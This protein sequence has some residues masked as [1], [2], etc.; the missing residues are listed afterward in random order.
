M[1]CFQPEWTASV[2]SFGLRTTVSFKNVWVGAGITFSSGV[3]LGSKLLR[4]PPVPRLYSPWFVLT[5][6]CSQDE[7][8]MPQQKWNL[9]QG[10]FKKI[11]I[12]EKCCSLLLQ[13][14]PVLIKVGD[15][16]AVKIGQGL[17]TIPW[18]RVTVHEILRQ[19]KSNQQFVQN[20]PGHPQT[21]ELT[22]ELSFVLTGDMLTGQ[23]LHFYWSAAGFCFV[24]ITDAEDW[25][26]LR[27]QI[28]ERVSY[29]LLLT[30]WTN[31]HN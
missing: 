16:A 30:E 2:A 19:L 8:E 22:N 23:D 29:L 11:Y 14:V 9:N 10:P 1:L 18:C 5:S 6:S 25:S 7:T 31:N 15:Y 20:R 24:F 12:P 3:L 26:R 28:I 4:H 21:P 13:Q 17:N 27:N